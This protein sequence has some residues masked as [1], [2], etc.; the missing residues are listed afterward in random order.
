[1]QTIDAKI[2]SN[3]LYAKTLLTPK[4]SV[5][6][7]YADFLQGVPKTIVVDVDSTLKKVEMHT[8]FKRLN[9]TSEQ[10]MSVNNA[11]VNLT[12]F[13]VENYF[14]FDSSYLFSHKKLEAEVKQK[15]VFNLL[16]AYAS[17][18]NVDLTKYPSQLPF[19]KFSAELAGDAQS[20]VGSVKTE[21]LMLDIKSKDYKEFLLHMNSETLALSSFTQL[22][23][24]LQKNNLSIKADAV[25]NISPFSMIGEFSS[26][27]LYSSVDGSINL[28]KKSQLMLQKFIPNS[29]QRFFKKYPMQKFSPLKFVYY[30][31]DEKIVLNIDVKM[32]DVTLFKKGSAFNGFGNFG[33]ESFKVKGDTSDKQITLSTNI[34]SL[35]A[36]LLEFDLINSDAD[37][38]LDAQAN[39]EA[40][41]NYSEKIEI[42]SRLNIP[43]LSAKVD[44]KT[45]YR[46]E[47]IYIEST[48]TQSDISI[49]KYSLD[50]MNHTF[51][52]H[53]KS[54]I[55]FDEQ[56]ILNL[57]EF[58]IYDNLLLTG[59]L[60]PMEM[61][62]ELRIKS[63]K[64]KY[65]AKEANVKC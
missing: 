40:T 51:Y 23:E 60:N 18:L 2:N 53:K 22:P 12:Y 61:K 57:K 9:L 55:S 50:F 6:N 28:D 34:Q 45:T 44:T 33:F 59:L 36:T 17:E 25:L 27:G 4:E 16:G 20:L 63:D 26:K 48:M 52:S 37:I 49:D 8:H 15:G 5:V 56:N 32:F 46:V 29:N 30:N 39:I 11:N 47:N 38:F 7:K 42:K 3:R 41:L 65:E 1:M 43:W 31:E 35:N 64:F 62:G 19:D 10:N 13:I 21:Q 14:S 58:W 54:K 24:M